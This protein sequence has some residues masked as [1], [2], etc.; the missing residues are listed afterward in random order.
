MFILEINGGNGRILQITSII[1]S[2]IG[3]NKKI[4]L[5]I[6]YATPCNGNEILKIIPKIYTI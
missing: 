5:Y 4:K 2:F 3:D 6:Q 1:H